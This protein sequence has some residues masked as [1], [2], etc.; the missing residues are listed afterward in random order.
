MN[1]GNGS[2]SNGR[3]QFIPIRKSDILDALVEHGQ[4]TSE[5]CKAQ[6]RQVCRMLGAIFHF[7]YFERLEILRRDYYYFDP[8]H[9]PRSRFDA[10]ALERAYR[11]LIE[12]FTKVLKGANFVEVSHAEVQQEHRESALVRVTLRAPIEQFREVRFFRRGHHQEIFE[13]PRWFG[14]GRKK[15]EA[16]VHDDVV[17]MVA[18]K[19]EADLAGRTRRKLRA[20]RKCRPGAVLIKYFRNIASADLNALFPN[21]EVVMSRFDKIF[22]GVPALAGS[23]PILLNLWSTVTVLF[24]VAGAYLGI[25]GAVEE[26]QLKTALAGVSGLIALGGFI[27][28]QWTKYQRQSLKYQKEL[29]DN[30]YYRNINNNAGIFD[31]IIGAAEEQECK[32]ALLAYYFL[33]TAGYPLTQDELDR[34]IEQRIS[35]TFGVGLHLQIE[36]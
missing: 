17:L 21:V 10:T 19:S 34:R 26:S 16:T 15:V 33:S 31:Y 18:M 5:A 7:E 2:T 25:S 28:R 12:S 30:V 8:E 20:H 22:L 3:D 23:V 13:V 14:L 36:Q 4:L 11:E 35:N 1:A 29:T 24:L 27:M 32:E 9:D 6:F